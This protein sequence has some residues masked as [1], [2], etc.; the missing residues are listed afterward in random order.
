MDRALI[1]YDSTGKIW[2][3][4]Y[5][6]TTPP[7][8]VPYVWCDIP[9]GA[10][11][12]HVDVATGTVIFTELPETDLGKLQQQMKYMLDFVSGVE[13]TVLDAMRNSSDAISTAEVAAD[14]AAEANG[15]ATTNASDITNIQIALAEVYEM[16]LSG[17]E[18]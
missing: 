12:D 2:S 8:G 16:L 11:I 18:A 6:D 7:V 9:P 15:T 3:I 17:M 5:G 14:N 13:G 1:I 4:T 10:I